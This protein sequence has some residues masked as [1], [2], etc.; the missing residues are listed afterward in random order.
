MAARQGFLSAHHDV[1]VDF[2]EDWRR[3]MRWLYDPAHRVEAVEILASVTRQP[4]SAYEDWVFSKRDY[5]RNPDV[6]PNLKALQNNLNVQKGIGAARAFDRC[7][8]IFR[9]LSGRGGG[10]TTRLRGRVNGVMKM[11]ISFEEVCHTYRPPRG[12]PVLALER[13]SLEVREREF[14]ALLGPSGCGKSTLLYLL[15]GFLPVEAGAI[16][17]AG[18]PVTAPGPD[19]GIVFQNFALYPWK[20]VRQNILYGLEKQRSR[21]RAREPRTRADRTRTSRRISRTATPRNSPAG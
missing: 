6:I 2:F 14:M 13:V 7:R 8:Q 15:G 18:K 10:A 9:S 19:R 11:G 17:V 20:T 16:R 4:A 3:A 21:G 5:Y 1:L 12:A